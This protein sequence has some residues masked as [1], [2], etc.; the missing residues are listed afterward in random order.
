MG[1]STQRTPT[2]RFHLPWNFEYDR[3]PN[4][5]QRKKTSMKRPTSM[6]QLFRV[7]KKSILGRFAP[8]AAQANYDKRIIKRGSGLLKPH[9]AGKEP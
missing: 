9:K 3:P 1:Y 8:C 4:P 7:Y 6:F 5:N 2:K